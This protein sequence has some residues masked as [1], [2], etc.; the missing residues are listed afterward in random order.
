MAPPALALAAL[1]APWAVPPAPADALGNL[2]VAAPQRGAA[3]LD[4]LWRA[5]LH[6]RCRRSTDVD[7]IIVCGREPAERIA[8]PPIPGQVPRLIAGEAPSG[9]GAMAAGGCLRLCHQPVGISVNPISLLRDPMGTLR[10][11]LRG[12]R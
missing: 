7:E 8:F 1:A 3:D 9:A 2:E 11:A 12:R 4:S 5:G 6:D 10:N